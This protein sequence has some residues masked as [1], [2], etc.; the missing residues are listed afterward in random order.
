MKKLLIRCTTILLAFLAGAGCMSY[1]TYM[2]NR[3]MTAA[4]A[5]ATL[6]VA[7]AE[8]EGQLCNEMHGYVEPMDGSYMKESLLGL[9]EDHRLVIAVEKYNAHIEGLSYEVRSLDMGRLIEDREHVPL[10]DDGRYVRMELDFKDLMERGEKYLLLL[11]AE[12]E[13]HG[14]VYFYSQISYL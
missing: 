1:M 14:E 12:T 11:K 8:W 9:S 2:G 13:E 3:D 7:Y 6:P 5:G 10:E 4:M